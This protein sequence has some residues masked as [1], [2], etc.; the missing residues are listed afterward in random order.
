MSVGKEFSSAAHNK[1]FSVW[2]CNSLTVFFF[3]MQR[4]SSPCSPRKSV[5]NCMMSNFSYSLSIWSCIPFL[6]HIPLEFNSG[7]L[8]QCGVRFLFRIRFSVLTIKEAC[9]CRES[10]MNHP[11]AEANLWFYWKLTWIKACSEGRCYH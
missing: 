4:L 8:L 7:L 5:H 6:F 9:Q 1:V 10:A 2:Y 3:R 11:T